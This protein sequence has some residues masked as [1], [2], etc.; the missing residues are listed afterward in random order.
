MLSLEEG[1]VRTALEAMA[2]G[3]QVVLTPNTGTSDF[4]E[5][6]VNGEIVPIRDAKAAAEAIL[7][8]W[9]RA[10]CGPAPRVGDLRQKLSFETFAR[11][12]IVQLRSLGLAF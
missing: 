7:K 6:G 9:E 10:Q 5:P 4:V 8:C 2:C 3:L 1:M 12:F 11:D